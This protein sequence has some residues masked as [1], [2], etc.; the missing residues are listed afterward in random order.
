MSFFKAWEKVRQFREDTEDAALSAIT[1]GDNV[2]DDF[3]DNFIIVCNNREGMA[4]LLGVS[5]DKVATWPATIKE[6]QNAAGKSNPDVKTNNKVLD[7]GNNNDKLSS[8][9]TE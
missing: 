8:M 4:A 1:T 3:W 9:E 2:A 6:K 7:T 5:S